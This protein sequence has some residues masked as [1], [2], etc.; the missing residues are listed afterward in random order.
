MS[1]F[2]YI[3]ELHIVNTNAFVCFIYATDF[4]L[5]WLTE[6]GAVI[7]PSA[8][9]VAWKYNNNNNIN[10]TFIDTKYLACWSFSELV[11]VTDLHSTVRK[12]F[13]IACFIVLVCSCKGV[14][15]LTAAMEL[16]VRDTK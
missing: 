9:K 4:E 8:P 2:Y 12:S 5:T 6:Y 10:N 13:E 1:E 3:V 16:N 15:C 7:F 14:E 11:K